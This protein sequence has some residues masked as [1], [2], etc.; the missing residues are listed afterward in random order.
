[1]L[2]KFRPFFIIACMCK[3]FAEFPSY[4][5]TYWELNN[6][7]WFNVILDA[8]FSSLVLNSL[9]FES[10]TQQSNSEMK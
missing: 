4:V 5:L 8:N 10:H 7:L 3:S 6:M 9:P 1:M 2:V